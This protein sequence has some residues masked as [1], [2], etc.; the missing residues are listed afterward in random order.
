[1]TD[2]T[3]RMLAAFLAAVCATLLIVAVNAGSLP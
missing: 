3:F 2:Q 1:M